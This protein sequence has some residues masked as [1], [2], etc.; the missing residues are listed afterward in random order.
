MQEETMQAETAEPMA[1]ELAAEPS[2]EA[3]EDTSEAAEQ[4]EQDKPLYFGLKGTLPLNVA[5]FKDGLSLINFGA[6]AEMEL[7]DSITLAGDASYSLTTL[8]SL[9]GDS[10]VLFYLPLQAGGKYYF[11]ENNTGWFAGAGLSANLMVT[12]EGT[13]GQ[14]GLPIGIHLN[15]GYTIQSDPYRLNTGLDLAI[16]PTSL[17]DRTKVFPQLYVSFLW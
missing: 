5:A 11:G 10:D 7:G 3:E 17:I 1:E 14:W 2:A 15:G 12:T 16:I 9:F 8:F 13:S 6:A 4:M